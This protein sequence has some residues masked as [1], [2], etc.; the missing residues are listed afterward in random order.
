MRIFVTLAFVIALNTAIAPVSQAQPTP[1]NLASL[2]D[3]LDAHLLEIARLWYPRTVDNE[4]GGFYERFS[5]DWTHQR[6]NAKSVVYQSR[7]TWTAAAIAGH[8][9]ELT[10]EF[11]PYAHH[12]IAGLYKNL[13]DDEYGGFYWQTRADGTPNPNNMNKHAYG[14]AFVV[15]A[16]ASVHQQTN[17]PASLELALEAYNFLEMHAHDRV[18]NGYNEYLTR[19]GRPILPQ[20]DLNANPQGDPI[21]TLVGFKSMNTHIHMLEAY[22]ELYKVHPDPHLRNRLTELHTLVRDTI[23]VPPGALNM[24]FTPDW[25]AIPAHDSIGHDIETAFLLAE[26]AAALG[27]PDDPQTWHVARQ[28][29]D[30]ALRYGWDERFGGFYDKAESFQ[31][32]Y[33]LEKIWWTQ[34]EGLNALAVMHQRFGNETDRYYIALNRQW[35]FIKQHQID[36]ENG[37]W[38]NTLNRDG[39]LPNQQDKVSQWKAAYHNARALIHTSHILRQL[40]EHR[41]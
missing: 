15:Y 14:I 37:G 29:V 34:A 16:A 21:G 9:P 8:M 39:S 31:A 33:A 36:A 24:F 38:H 12:G 1:E 7:Q 11:L 40:A 17:D 13:H 20:E 28:L 41:D 4:N 26:S 27:I 5:H 2:A 6:E 22:T 3:E 23:A 18:N 19:S 25:R 30:H 10:E 32:A 35:E